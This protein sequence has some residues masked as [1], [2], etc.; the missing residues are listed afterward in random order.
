VWDPADGKHDRVL[1]YQSNSICS[2]LTMN[3]LP[4][5]TLEIYF[6]EEVNEVG[7]QD[8]HLR[9]ET[10]EVKITKTAKH[11]KKITIAGLLADSLQRVQFK[12]LSGW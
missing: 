4:N 12:K 7:A 11:L 1:L 8:H 3:L 10:G 9:T 2:G 6:I 5:N